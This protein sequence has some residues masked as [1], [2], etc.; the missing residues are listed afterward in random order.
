MGPL[1]KIIIPEDS[2]KFLSARNSGLPRRIINR[3]R[4]C[5][6]ADAL[7]AWNSHL[8]QR[9]FCSSFSVSAKRSRTGRITLVACRKASTR[10]R[11]AS[12]CPSGVNEV[13][14]GHEAIRVPAALYIEAVR[15][16]KAACW[17]SD[18]GRLIRSV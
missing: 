16:Y 2:R 17:V 7:P 14:V 3:R 15:S 18:R 6:C 1:D 4:R 13:S 5:C 10:F 11:L 8:V 12:I 9:I